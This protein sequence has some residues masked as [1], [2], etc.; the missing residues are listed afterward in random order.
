MVHWSS[1]SE[2]ERL[3]SSNDGNEEQKEQRKQTSM[4]PSIPITND[5]TAAW[6]STVLRASGTLPHGEVTSLEQEPTGDF[7]GSHTHRLFVHY[8]SDAPAMAPSSLLL[9]RNREN[10]WSKG[11]GA[12]EVKCYSLFGSLPDHPSVTV[13]CYTAAYDE[14]SG[15]SYLL[16]QDLTTTHIQP[17]T[18]SQII[19]LVDSVPPPVSLERVVRA[20]AQ[21]HAYWWEHPLLAT[22]AFELSYWYRDAERFEYYLQRRI[23]SWQSLIA[24]EASWFPDDLR[25]LYAQILAQLRLYWREYLASRMQSRANLTLIHGD[26][27][28]NNFLCPRNP[29]S[30]APT[31]LIDWQSPTCAI[32]GYDLANLLAT[33]WTP[34]QR[35]DQQREVSALR[36]YHTTLQANGVSSYTWDD[37]VLDYQHGLIYWLLVPVQDSFDGSSRDYWWPKMQCLAAAFRDW[38]CTDLLRL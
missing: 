13:P 29:A 34:E 22:P 16:L 9:K 14:E 32:V 37:L 1:S 11:A 5:I 33:F 7:R 17:R 8:S 26:A 25:D 28:F 24:N 12:E 30:E 21:F 4:G 20:L 6:L 19:R 10:A 31:Y 36:A 3:R 35:H 15:N 2:G 27:Y 38:H 23:A 18:R